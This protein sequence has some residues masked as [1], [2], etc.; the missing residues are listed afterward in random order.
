MTQCAVNASFGHISLLPKSEIVVLNASERR[1]AVGNSGKRSYNV[2]TV[3]C[4]KYYFASYE[5][6]M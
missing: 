2:Q 6:T 3:G 4:S 1:L 5:V